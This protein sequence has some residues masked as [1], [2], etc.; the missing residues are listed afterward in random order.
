MDNIK[1]TEKLKGMFE[2][3]Y[4]KASLCRQLDI[5]LPTLYKRMV[6]NLW[7]KPQL[8]VIEQL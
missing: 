5:T 8:M 4:T 7:S 1:A 3:G 6:D 2:K